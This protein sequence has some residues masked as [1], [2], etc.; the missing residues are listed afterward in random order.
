MRESGALYKSYI[1]AIN[2]QQQHA[3]NSAIV[4]IVKR[5]GLISR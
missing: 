4:A 3:E 5:F 1:K 2:N